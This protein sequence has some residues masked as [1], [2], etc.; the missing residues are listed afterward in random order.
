MSWISWKEDYLIGVETLDNDHKTL[1]GLINEFHDAFQQSRQRR[2]LVN[3]LNRLVAYAEEHF[4]REEAAMKSHDYP[5]T[6]NHHLLHEE[7]FDTIFA[8]N[9]RIETDSLPLDR[10][11]IAFLK[12]WLSS[13]ILEHDLQFAYFI[14][15]KNSGDGK[16]ASE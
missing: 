4:D 7:L 1:F 9:T 11:I 6:D 13:H 14:R 15:E 2:D 8:L 3:I 10:E 16:S 12:H 5:E